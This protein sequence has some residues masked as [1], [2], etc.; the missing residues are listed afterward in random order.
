MLSSLFIELTIGSYGV[1]VGCIGYNK[2]HIF[3]LP[4]L[5]YAA[6]VV[7]L[8]LQSLLVYNVSKGARLYM[9]YLRGL[10]YVAKT[11][12]TAGLILSVTLGLQAFI[13][14]EDGDR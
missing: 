3:S 9:A 4:A 8:A 11:G 5:V 6:L 12:L 13:E 1:Y 14:Y 2:G 7:V 10:E